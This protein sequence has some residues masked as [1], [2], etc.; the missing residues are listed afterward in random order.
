MIIS[1]NGGRPK[2]LRNDL[3]V[4]TNWVRLRLEGEPPN[5]E[6][7]GATVLVFT[8]SVTQRFVVSTSSSYLSQSETNPVLAGLGGATGADSV[9]VKWPRGK[10]SRVGRI[11][12]GNEEVI[13]ESSTAGRGAIDS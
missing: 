9:L 13:S 7:V 6:A 1:T 2:F 12:A 8:E 11:D 4:G 5:L 10:V 3:T